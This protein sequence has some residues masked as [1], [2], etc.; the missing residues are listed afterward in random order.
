MAE[1]LHNGNLYHLRNDVISYVLMEMPGGVLSHLYFGARLAGLNAAT[2][3]R[4][5]M[6]R[7]TELNRQYKALQQ[8]SSAEPAPQAA[9]SA[10]INGNRKNRCSISIN[11]ITARA[12][13][14]TQ[15]TICARSSCSF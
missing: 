12:T 8:Q 15:I 2:L 11:V 1:I 6:Q 13:I 14:T 4:H 7:Y 10:K 3:L 9:A 5:V